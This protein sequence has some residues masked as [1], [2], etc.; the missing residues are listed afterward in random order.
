MLALVYA[1]V[2]SIGI[3]ASPPIIQVFVPQKARGGKRA[4]GT[5]SLSVLFSEGIDCFL[6]K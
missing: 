2:F 4:S 1:S 5:L 6:K 3:I